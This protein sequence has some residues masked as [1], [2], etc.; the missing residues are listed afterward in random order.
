MEIH[1]KF[2]VAIA[3]ASGNRRLT[4]LAERLVDETVRLF[5]PGFHMGDHREIVD[6]L[7]TGDGA[8]ARAAAVNHVLVTQDRARKQEAT[9]F[10]SIA[11]GAVHDS[12]EPHALRLPSA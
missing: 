3:R 2:H 12:R 5:A 9:G 1:R 7:K 4:V 8:R 11:D 10:S 6:A